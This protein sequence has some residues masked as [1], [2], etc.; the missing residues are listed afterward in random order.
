MVATL[1]LSDENSTRHMT[2]TGPIHHAQDAWQR[3]IERVDEQDWPAGSLYVIATPIGNLADLTLRAWQALARMDVIAAED[4]RQSR[5]LMDAW[6]IR[7]PLMSAHR[8]NEAAAAEAIVQRLQAGE[9]VGLISDAGSPGVSDPGGRIVREVTKAGLRVIPFPGPSAVVS[10]L[11]ACGATTD[12]NP[13]FAFA[14]FA[15]PK[16]TARQRWMRRWSS[17]DCAVAFYEV[18]HRIRACLQDLRG[19]LGEDRLVT[20][21]RELT[22][23]FEE[24]HTFPLSDAISWLDERPHRE[25]GEFVVVI[26]PIARM[27]QQMDEEIDFSAV[28]PW[29]DALLENMSVRDVAKLVSKVTGLGK[30]LVYARALT[31]S[32]K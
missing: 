12:E 20:C 23:R 30:D 19:L 32:G 5:S 2:P 27:G 8:H 15:P 7:T 21:A 26:H 18:P 25:Q 6:G 24:I 29:V 17:I 16:S 13:A 9:R 28:D 11:M 3:L 22:K 1:T 10:A 14:G 31:R 4:T